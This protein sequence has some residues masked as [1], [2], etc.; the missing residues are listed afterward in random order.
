MA[1]YVPHC[2]STGYPPL[3]EA[4]GAY[5]LGA[6]DKAESDRVS[7]H[8]SVC[9][10]CRLEYAQMIE[11]VVL[12]AGATEAEVINGSST[13]P[14]RAVL[15]RILA[16]SWRG[17]AYVHRWRPNYRARRVRDRARPGR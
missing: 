9:A 4:L 10:G 2:T 17:P 6:L 15:G 3:R 5:V 7:A 13:R 16:D 12:L 14:E 11:M 1:D 8:L